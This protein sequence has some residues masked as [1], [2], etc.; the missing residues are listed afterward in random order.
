MIEFMIH[1]TFD[2]MIVQSVPLVPAVFWTVELEQIMIK[3]LINIGIR[4]LHLLILPVT[5]CNCLTLRTWMVTDHPRFHYVLLSLLTKD[6][7]Q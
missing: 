3:W 6:K 4:T 7:L 5:I 1:T 2:I